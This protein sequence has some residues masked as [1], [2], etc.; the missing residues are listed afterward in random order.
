MAGGSDMHVR[1]TMSDDLLSW[2]PTWK[3]PLP[4]AGALWAPVLFH[5]PPRAARRGSGIGGAPLLLLYTESSSCIRERPKLGDQVRPAQYPTPVTFRCV[6]WLSG[7]SGVK[8]L[9][10]GLRSPPGV[11]TWR[12]HQDGDV[13]RR[14]GVEQPADGVVTGGG[15]WRAQ[16][17]SP[18]LLH[19]TPPPP[20]PAWSYPTQL[21]PAHVYAHH[22]I[23][24]VPR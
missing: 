21:S 8:D 15:G 13:D 12:R 17:I 5:V 19:I 9:P 2:L 24:D 4:Q 1:A 11:C 23:Y 10:R 7:A 18:Q 16:G 3:L 14:A 20:P 6:C 22:W